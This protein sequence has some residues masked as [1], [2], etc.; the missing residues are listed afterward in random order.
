MKAA[1]NSWQPGR[2]RTVI[3]SLGSE[4]SSGDCVVVADSPSPLRS[5]DWRNRF[6]DC[7]THLYDEHHPAT[8]SIRDQ[9]NANGSQ[10]RG[11]ENRK[12]EGNQP[13]QRTVLGKEIRPATG[14][15]PSLS[16]FIVGEGEPVSRVRYAAQTPRALDTGSP[17]P[18]NGLSRK[19]REAMRG[20]T[21][22]YP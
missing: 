12:R 11:Q 14:S 2:Y 16:E 7:S 20:E 8:L 19:R 13:W 1:R 18:K 10:A 3:D 21:Q 15:F 17:S 5:G 6:R 9:R 22:V 4:P